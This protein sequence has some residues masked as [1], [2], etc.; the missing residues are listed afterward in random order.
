[1]VRRAA[2][3]LRPPRR[4]KPAVTANRWV[5]LGLAPARTAWFSAVA[6][7]A[8]AG[9]L[10]V[11]FLKCL[12]ADE[13]RVRL[14]SDRP[15]SA[16]LLDA[17]MPGADRDLL[18]DVLAAGCL[19]IVVGPAGADA[20]WVDLGAPVF[21]SDSFSPEDLV[22]TLAPARRIDRMQAL[23]AGPASTASP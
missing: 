3:H 12:S 9:S 22:D 15:A 20:R 23:S 1:R 16:V 7:W 5:V 18:A 11:E 17:R 14:R 6:Q 8:N 4:G 19:P 13:L 2:T 21:L 10:P